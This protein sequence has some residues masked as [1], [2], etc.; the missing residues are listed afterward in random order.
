MLLKTKDKSS[1]KRSVPFTNQVSY[2]REVI[3]ENLIC[4]ANARIED[5][6]CIQNHIHYPKVKILLS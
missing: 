4:E 5:V 6:I 3:S 2:I 1:C